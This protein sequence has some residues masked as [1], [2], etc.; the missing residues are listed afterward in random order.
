MSDFYS[1]QGSDLFINVK[2]QPRAS[3][4]ELAEILGRALKIRIKSPPVDGKANQHLIKFMAHTFKV[5]KSRIEL[6]S[7]HTSREKKLVIHNPVSL[8][9][10]IKPD[11][12]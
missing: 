9:D 10:C 7:G 12:Q 4:D 6:L 3:H 8:P 5:A 1:W 2:V 11:N